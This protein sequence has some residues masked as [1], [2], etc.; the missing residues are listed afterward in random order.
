MKTEHRMILRRLKKKLMDMPMSTGYNHM[1]RDG[2]ISYEREDRVE[3][4]R[5]WEI[6]MLMH[7]RATAEFRT[8]K[9]MR[10]YKDVSVCEE[11]RV[12]RKFINWALENGYSDD[13]TLERTDNS[14]DYTPD[15]C[16][17][18]TWK[19][20]AGNRRDSIR[21]QYGGENMCLKHACELAGTSYT[22]VKKRMGRGWDFERAITQPS[23]RKRGDD[24]KDKLITMKVTE[25]ER[26]E[27]KKL[28]DD[29]GCSLSTLIRMLLKREKEHSMTAVKRT[30]SSVLRRAKL[31]A[32]ESEQR[33][34][35]I[36]PGVTEDV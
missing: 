12:C 33:C 18:A 15:N 5:L 17:W 32:Q 6:W 30:V 35:V 31:R 14:G 26:E 8:E 13:L 4:R 25:E 24:M 2:L 1:I 7:R 29:V 16:K 11:W 9:V 28:A 36:I 21:V 22:M 10:T 19:E 23:M 3:H 34:P 20:Q 27:W